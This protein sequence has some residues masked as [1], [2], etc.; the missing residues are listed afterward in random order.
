MSVERY[1][2]NLPSVHPACKAKNLGYRWETRAM[3]CLQDIRLQI[4]GDFETG[5]LGHSRLSKVPP[6]DNLVSYSTSIATMAVSRIVSEIRRLLGKKIAQSPPLHSAPQ[7]GVKPSELTKD[8]R[9]RKT[10]MSG[11]S[12]G[13][14]ISTKGLA[15]LT[16]S[17]RV[18]LRHTDRRKCRSIYP[19]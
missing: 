5:G 12:G 8:P 4:S 1:D 18:T 10:R 13:K 9:W 2:V 15:V 14:R 11:L 6:F 7:L 17:T 16:Q 19:R 3:S